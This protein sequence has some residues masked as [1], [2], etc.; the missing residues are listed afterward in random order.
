MIVVKTVSMPGQQ[1]RERE[2]A[3]GIPASVFDSNLHNVY[4]DGETHQI[5]L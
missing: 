2:N 1:E 3:P 5:V 4:V